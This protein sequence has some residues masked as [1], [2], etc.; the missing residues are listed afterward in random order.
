MADLSDVPLEELERELTRRRGS[1][2]CTCGKW[3]TYMGVWDADGYTR[4]CHGCLRST[5]RCTC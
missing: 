3:T 2:R 1:E 4:R 5:A